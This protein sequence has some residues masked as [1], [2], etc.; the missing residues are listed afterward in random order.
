MATMIN[1][2]TLEQQIGDALAM[3][4]QA[5]LRALLAPQHPAD[6]AD[7]IDR[8]DE[9]ERMQVFRLLPLAQAVDVLSETGVDATR[10]LLTRLRP[11]E[12]GRLL[13]QMPN[14]DVAKF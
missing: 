7:V 11:Q 8:L 4:D 3:N 6:I 5:T 9:Y 12:V 1:L 10:E 2:G 14:D 13:D